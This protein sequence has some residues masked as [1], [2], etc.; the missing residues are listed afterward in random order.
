[1]PL[2]LCI[3]D[4]PKVL[5][6]HKAILQARGHAVLTA[7]DGAEGLEIAR[8]YRID[9]VVLDFN[10]ADMD[11]NE[12]AALLT[13]EHPKLPIVVC[14]GSLA[15]IPEALKWFADTWVHKGEGPEALL[16][17]IDNLFASGVTG[18]KSPGQELAGQ[19]K[20]AAA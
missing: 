17:A 2:I 18:K 3:D 19:A 16:F 6:M 15:D 8:Q 1:M 9:A 7:T 5:E 13:R 10:M 12:A 4:D 20:I 11:G 14:S